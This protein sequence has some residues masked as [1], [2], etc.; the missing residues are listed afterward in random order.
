MST[1][2]GVYGTL[3]KGF[4]LHSILEESEFIGEYSPQV[5][6]RM[7]NVGY[8]PALLPTE[9]NNPI[10]FEVYEVDDS[11]LH[12][13]DLAEGVP[14]LYHRQVVDIE[15]LSVNIYIFTDVEWG[16]GLEPIPSGNFKSF[17][18]AV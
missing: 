8:Y 17:L 14:T 10:T 9:E 15:G 3:R 16:E 12:R 6:Y 5:P 2:V 18:E 13:L 11:T 1:L 7:V 4:G